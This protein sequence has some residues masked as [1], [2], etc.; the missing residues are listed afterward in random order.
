MNSQN[1]RKKRVR[2]YVI[3]GVL[4]VARLFWNPKV[5]RFL[6]NEKTSFLRF[7]D[8]QYIMC[9]KKPRRE[10]W[11]KRWERYFPL[12][13]GLT[14]LE[15]YNTKEHLFQDLKKLSSTEHLDQEGKKLSSPILNHSK[16]KG[17]RL[18]RTALSSHVVRD[19]ILTRLSEYPSVADYRDIV[20]FGLDLDLL[21]A[22]QRDLEANVHRHFMKLAGVREA[23]RRLWV[24]QNLIEFVERFR[25]VWRRIREDDK[26][27]FL[28]HVLNQAR[29]FIEA[30][31]QKEEEFRDYLLRI[32]AISR[33][34]EVGCGQDMKRY[35]KNID[36]IT[37]ANKR[38]IETYVQDQW[39][40]SGTRDS[41]FSVVKKAIR[42]MMRDGVLSDGD[43]Q[44]LLIQQRMSRLYATKLGNR[45]SLG[46]AERSPVVVM[47]TAIGWAD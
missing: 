22:K 27:Y 43:G 46:V 9:R 24:H 45:L 18:S 4:P 12:V 41:R 34:S 38:N 29:F 35:Q 47:D 33:E 8:I 17:Y 19:H 14:G 21:M 20:Y 37:S 31:G 25:T 7:G 16:G 10:Q 40:R 6:R 28:G 13:D 1:R 11:T 44:W 23:L 5:K 15:A 26:G 2:K 32:Q 36:R 39:L 3:A 30:S 42:S